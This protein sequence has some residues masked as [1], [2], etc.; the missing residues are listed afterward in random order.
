M[1]LTLAR[2]T[3]TGRRNTHCATELQT[4]VGALSYDTQ[5]SLVATGLGLEL[6]TLLGGHDG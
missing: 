1:V 5:D 4:T 2:A 6:A 3:R